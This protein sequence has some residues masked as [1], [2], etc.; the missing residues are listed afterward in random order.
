LRRPMGFAA[1]LTGALA[2]GDL[3]AITLFSRPGEGTLPM[4]MYQLMGAY[5]MDAAYGAA[6]L[7]VMLS[8]G[9]FWVFDKGGRAHAVV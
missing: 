1:G 7:L 3:G 5:Q 2:M 6:L 8:L 9:L 4:A